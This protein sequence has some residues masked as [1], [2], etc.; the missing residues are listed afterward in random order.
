MEGEALT[1][2]MVKPK[3]NEWGTVSERRGRAALVRRHARHGDG[4]F[5]RARCRSC[6][7]RDLEKIVE[8][9]RGKNE[10]CSL[11]GE[12]GLIGPRAWAWG[13]RTWARAGRATVQAWGL[14]RSG[15]NIAS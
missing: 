14:N 12:A 5:E 9:G 10:T 11:V 8:E 7:C 6:W 13:R 3:E 15:H 1:E 4:V 2:T